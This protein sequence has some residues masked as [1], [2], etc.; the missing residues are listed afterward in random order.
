MCG[1]TIFDFRWAEVHGLLSQSGVGLSARSRRLDGPTPNSNA[2]PESLIPALRAGDGALEAVMLRWWLTPSWSKGVSRAH[3]MFNARA[4]TAADR[5]AFRDP[6]RRRR[7]VAPVSGF[8]EWAQT[9]STTKQPYCFSR[10]D[11]QPMF[12]AALW[13]RWVGDGATVESCAIL[14]R[15]ANERM[16][17][18][19]QRMPCVLEPDRVD[20]WCAPGLTDPAGVAEFLGPVSEGVLVA[21]AVDPRVNS[22]RGSE[23]M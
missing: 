17:S 19:H 21:R 2:A 6:F 11:H 7:C 23:P 5:P 9:G 16:A 18:Y 8:Y 4:E 15:A 3:A 13:D 20:A 10:A 14:T 1:R 22:T 12:L